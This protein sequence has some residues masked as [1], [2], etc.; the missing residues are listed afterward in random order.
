MWRGIHRRVFIPLNQH[1][2]EAM[3]RGRWFVNKNEKVWQA[4]GTHT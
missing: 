2:A 1:G 4:M 3:R